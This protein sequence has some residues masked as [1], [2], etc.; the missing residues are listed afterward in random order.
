MAEP[1]LTREAIQIAKAIAAARSHQR[2]R[3]L[4]TEA[5]LEKSLTDLKDAIAVVDTWGEIASVGG[6]K[7]LDYIVSL[8]VSYLKSSGFDLLAKFA[9]KG[10]EPLVAYLQTEAAKVFRS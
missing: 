5:E 9:M 1:V 6:E 3:P 7:V 8:G 4:V 2:F 10:I